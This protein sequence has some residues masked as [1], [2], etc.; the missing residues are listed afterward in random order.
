MSRARA[1]VRRANPTP[2]LVRSALLAM[3][4]GL[5][6]PRPAAA[7]TA[8]P[9]V[10]AT[11]ADSALARMDTMRRHLSSMHVRRDSIETG[12]IVTHWSAWSQGKTPRFIRE[13]IQQEDFGS[14]TNEY[15][16]EHGELRAFVSRGDRSL[17]DPRNPEA[18]AY[19][20]RVVWGRAGDVS[21]AD[22]VVSGKPTPVED[23]EPGGAKTRGAWLY[24]LVQAPAH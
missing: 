3:V 22:K 9:A 7:A 12:G 14:R 16:Y 23:T 5:A 8:A 18:G 13:T 24:Q 21:R 1:F 11:Y 15:F 19:V 6:A 20:L 4:L 10:H 17:T 2:T